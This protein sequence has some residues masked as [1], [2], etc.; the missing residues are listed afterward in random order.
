MSRKRA[1]DKPGADAI[2]DEILAEGSGPNEVI[3]ANAET[4]VAAAQG[5]VD[6]RKAGRAERKRAKAAAGAVRPRPTREPVPA[7]SR[8]VLDDRV[9][10]LPDTLDH[11]P[12]D[13]PR[14]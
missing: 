4:L 7:P 5:L 6:K 11:G 2:P 12:Y 13:L 3:D 14:P 8:L 1:T 9:H 10:A